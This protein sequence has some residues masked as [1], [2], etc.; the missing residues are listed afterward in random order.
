MF[1]RFARSVDLS[2]SYGPRPTG[3]GIQSIGIGDQ[4]QVEAGMLDQAQVEA[5]L[6]DQ[7]H[8]E[9]GL[10][11]QRQVE[12]GLLDQ[13]EVAAGLLGTGLSGVGLGTVS[14]SNL[15]ASIEAEK[16]R[17]AAEK[18]ERERK[19]A[20]AA[21]ETKATVGFFGE[22]GAAI[23]GLVGTIA[24]TEQQRRDIK[25]RE[26]QNELWSSL[27]PPPTPPGSGIGGALPMIA[28]MGAGG[29]LLYL[30]LKKKK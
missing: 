20:I 25:A 15:S 11:D 14:F 2:K 23:A 4:Y 3:V 27:R 9:A 29:V 19:A 16:A 5:G 26:R 28:V 10:L 21:G 18:I 6:L 17:L 7:Y 22:L 13:Y 24:L 30:Y 12:A 8:V 1:T